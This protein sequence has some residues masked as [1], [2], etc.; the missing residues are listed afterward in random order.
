[1]A[2]GDHC[3]MMSLP[4]DCNVRLETTVNMKIGTSVYTSVLGELDG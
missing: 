4:D 2:L 3:M 1:M